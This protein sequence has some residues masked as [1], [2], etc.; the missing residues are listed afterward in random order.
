MAG[1]MK[2]MKMIIRERKMGEEQVS[3]IFSKKRFRVSKKLLRAHL[4][5]QISVG[6]NQSS[7]AV[8]LHWSHLMSV[9][10]EVISLL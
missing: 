2:K 7:L 4:R 5:T 9:K 6:L 1:K 10:M 3:S 8:E